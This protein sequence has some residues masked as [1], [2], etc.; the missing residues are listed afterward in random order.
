ML[1]KPQFKYFLYRLDNLIQKNS[2]ILTVPLPM[3]RRQPLEDRSL[4][5]T[6]NDYFS[7][8]H[9]FLEQNK[10][11]ILTSAFSKSINRQIIPEE[12][13][14][15]RVCLIKHGEFYHPSLIEAVLNKH[16]YKF[17][18]NVAISATGRHCML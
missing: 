13:E 9:S 18:V 6:Y 16:S 5:I 15:I 17:V 3:S 2:R 14:E 10:F 4:S 1:H 11:E 8:V 7:A 12:I